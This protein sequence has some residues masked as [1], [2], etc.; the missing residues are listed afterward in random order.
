MRIYQKLVRNVFYPLVMR[1]SGDADELRWL[2]EFERTQHLPPDELRRLQFCRLSALLSHAHARCPFYSER[3]DRVG[4]RPE[5]VRTL[6]DLARLPVLEK[7]DLQ[8][9][10][11]DMVAATGRRMTWSPIRPAARPARPCRSSS[12]RTACARG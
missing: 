6:E 7:S 2:R 9:H 1:R 10:S 5:N 8:R 12:A 3:F 11:A 4:F